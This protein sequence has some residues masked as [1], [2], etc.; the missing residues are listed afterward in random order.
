MIIIV[1]YG[2]GNL[3]SIK[4]MFKKIGVSAV[5]S[6]DHAEIDKAEKLILPGVGSFDTA[7]ERI[8]SSGLRPLLNKKALEDKIP[9]LGICLGMQLLTE[10]SDEGKLPGLGWIPGFTRRFVLP[11]ELNLK[12]PHM[13]WNRVF[14]TEP[15][16]LTAGLPEEPRYYFVH[17]Y[18][19]HATDRKNSILTTEYGVTFDSAIQRGNIMGVQFHPEKS[20]KFGMKL[21]GNF[22]GI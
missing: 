19:V 14:T 21:L 12:V 18:F 22:A 7:M 17:S 3:G 11:E 4:N 9:V 6:S 16:I 13:G 20:H 1:D 15:S 10:G 5:I 8:E 2:M